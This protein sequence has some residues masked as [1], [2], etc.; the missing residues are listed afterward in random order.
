MLRSQEETDSQL[1]LLISR[2][3]ELQRKNPGHELLTLVKI[4][5]DRFGVSFC[6]DFDSRCLPSGYNGEHERLYSMGHYSLAL[7]RAIRGRS[8]DLPP[9]YD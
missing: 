2:Y 5:E 9:K 8:Y 1:S 7:L 3:L 6:H 4:H